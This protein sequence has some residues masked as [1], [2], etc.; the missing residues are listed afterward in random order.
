MEYKEITAK[1]LLRNS[2][3]LIELLVVIAIIAI[4]AAMLLPALGKARQ[5]ALQ[6]ACSGNLKQIGTAVLMYTDDHDDWFPGML[7]SS[8]PF[9]TDLAPYLRHLTPTGSNFIYAKSPKDVHV[10]WCPAANPLDAIYVSGSTTY[11]YYHSCRAINFYLRT[12]HASVQNTGNELYTRLSH[13]KKPSQKMY[14]ADA[15]GSTLFSANTYPFKTTASTSSRLD[16]RHSG[17]V[18]ALWAD[19][20]VEAKKSEQFSSNTYWGNNA[21][22]I[23]DLAVNFT[24]L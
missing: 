1:L 2:F 4:L 24:F 15:V 7:N 12:T 10:Y 23:L 20:H 5:K 21:G 22:I 3:T 8:G 13:I 14:I 11:W 16:G 19:F 6:T 18:N 17:M 9:I